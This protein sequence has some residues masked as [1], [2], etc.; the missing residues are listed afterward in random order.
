VLH[1]KQRNTPNQ[2]KFDV[3]K[4]KKTKSITFHKRTTMPTIAAMQEKEKQDSGKLL[5]I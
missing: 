3:K 1:G 5:E 2:G 4:F